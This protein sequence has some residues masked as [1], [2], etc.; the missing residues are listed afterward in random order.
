M[1]LTKLVLD[2]LKML[3]GP[4]IIEVAYRL[5]EL[6]GVRS[7]NVKVK[8]ANAEALTLVITIEGSS[9]DFEKVRDALEKLNIIVQGVNEFSACRD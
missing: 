8:E 3:K 9:I 5:L 2:A 6:E 1:G 7:V 4:T